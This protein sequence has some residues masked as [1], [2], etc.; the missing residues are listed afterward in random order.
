[1][2]MYV[3]CVR[4]QKEYRRELDALNLVVGRFELP[5]MGVG[6]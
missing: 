5:D 2:D 3:T 6:N 1:M 4:V